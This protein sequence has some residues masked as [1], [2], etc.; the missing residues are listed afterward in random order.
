MITRSRY[1][2]ALTA[3]LG[4]VM[5]ILDA[6]VVNV[7]LVPMSNALKSDLSTI[8]WVVT[9]YFL[10]QAAVIPISGY[11]SS[12]FG[13]KRLFIICLALFTLGSF[14]CGISQNESMLI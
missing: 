6:T 9:G 8:Q 7:A 12:R 3:A 4:L 5:A 10:A 1:A 2:I 13:I 11:F 14:L